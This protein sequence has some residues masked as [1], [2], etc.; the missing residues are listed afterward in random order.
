MFFSILAKI[1]NW[2][3]VGEA[4]Y[5]GW[6]KIVHVDGIVTLEPQGSDMDKPKDA[7]MCNN[8]VLFVLL[9]NEDNMN[10]FQPKVWLWDAYE[11]NRLD[12]MRFLLMKGC[13]LPAVAPKYVETESRLA[14]ELDNSCR[15][16]Y[17]SLFL[18]YEPVE[19]DKKWEIISP[20]VMSLKINALQIIAGCVE[21]L[22]ERMLGGADLIPEYESPGFF[23]E[24][25]Y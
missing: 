22:Y 17:I 14:Y 1:S 19:L 13:K 9:P 21:L 18:L 4:L 10:Q 5:P 20:Y 3:E 12:V 7:N 6:K 24:L 8:D 2:N 23:N 25:P 11:Q 15:E 16:E